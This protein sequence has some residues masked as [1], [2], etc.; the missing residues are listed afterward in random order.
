MMLVLFAAVPIT[1]GAQQPAA[2][3][4]LLVLDGGR[5]A[6]IVSASD[7]VRAVAEGAL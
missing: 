2:A 7:I 1:G 5:L 3:A 4:R 6:G